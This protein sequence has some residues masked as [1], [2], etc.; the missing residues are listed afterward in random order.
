MDRGKAI[1]SAGRSTEG[2]QGPKEIHNKPN[3]MKFNEN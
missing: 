2:M 3:V 1:E